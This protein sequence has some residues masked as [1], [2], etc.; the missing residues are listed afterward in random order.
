MSGALQNAEMYFICKSILKDSA[1]IF[2]EQYIFFKQ[3]NNVTTFFGVYT[4]IYLAK[5]YPK[6]ERNHSIW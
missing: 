5:F 1:L 6:E 4:Y 2:Y 3:E